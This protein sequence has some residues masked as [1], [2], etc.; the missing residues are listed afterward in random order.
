[1]REH[2]YL[3]SRATALLRRQASAGPSR[4]PG[5][6]MLSPREL[7]VV[8]LYARGY[9]ASEMGREVFLSSKTVEGYLARAKSKLGLK[10]RREIVRFALEAGLLRTEDEA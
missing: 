7:S 10:N 3:P 9:T 4:Q 6:D 5:V 2:S 8:T 1:M